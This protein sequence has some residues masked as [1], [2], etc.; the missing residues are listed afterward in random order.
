MFATYQ[1]LSSIMGGTE[2]KDET[3]SVDSNGNVNNYVVIQDPISSNSGEI[4]ILLYVI[5]II[6]IIELLIFIYKFHRKNL[7]RKYTNPNSS[8]C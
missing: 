5:C 7:K 4:K 2:S 3:K 8:G 1:L 6:K